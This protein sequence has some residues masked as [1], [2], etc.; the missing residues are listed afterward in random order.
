VVEVLWAKAVDEFLLRPTYNLA[1]VPV[2]PHVATCARVDL[3]HPGCGGFEDRPELC[4]PRSECRLSPLTCH[5]QHLE[6]GHARWRRRATHVPACGRSLGTV[7]ER[8]HRPWLQDAARELR[9]N[10]KTDRHR[11]CGAGHQQHERA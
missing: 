9:R 4:F 10:C 7:N 3:D 5:P 6:F 11:R 8:V 1:K 2:N